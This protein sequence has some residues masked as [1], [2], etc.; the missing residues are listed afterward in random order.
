MQQSGTGSMPGSSR[1]S[2][3]SSRASSISNL[4]NSERAAGSSRSVAK[5]VTIGL[6]NYIY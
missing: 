3:S 2:R 4:A 1:S 6:G 5:Q